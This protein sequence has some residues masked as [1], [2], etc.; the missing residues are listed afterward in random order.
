METSNP[1]PMVNAEQMK[2]FVGRKVRS[3]L[4]FLKFEAGVLTGQSADNQQVVVRQ[5]QIASPISQ[6]VEVIGVVEGERTLRAEICTNFGDNF[7]LSPYNQLCQMA[8]A[9]YQALFV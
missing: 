1:S 3:V 4:R 6:F 9:E 2:R 5:V 8:N 7:D